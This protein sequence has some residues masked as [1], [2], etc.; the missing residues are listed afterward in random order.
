MKAL[1]VE[2]RGRGFI[3]QGIT[4]KIKIAL[5]EM[6]FDFCTFARRHAKTRRHTKMRRYNGTKI[7]RPEDPRRHEDTKTRRYAKTR[8]D[9]T[10]LGRH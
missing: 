10:S 9:F 5:V 7:R 8:R 6:D 4:L 3:N 2:G 1:I